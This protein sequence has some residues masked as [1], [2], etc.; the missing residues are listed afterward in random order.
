M[1]SYFFGHQDLPNHDYGLLG[2][3]MALVRA[4]DLNLVDSIW[5]AYENNATGDAVREDILLASRDPFAVDWYA[6]EYILRP[7]TTVQGSSAA[8]GG[9]FRKSTR[10]NQ[11]A[12]TLTWPGGSSNYPYIDFLDDY[13]GE[14]PSAAEHDQL[15][16]YV[17]TLGPGD[18]DGEEENSLTLTSPNGSEVWHIGSQ[19]DI[20]WTSTGVDIQSVRLSYSTDGFAN[21]N[22]S[23]TDNTPN[24]GKYP[25]WMPLLNSGT[26]SV[27]VSSASDPTIYDD[28]D[29]QF[30]IT[31]S[32]YREYIPFVFIFFFGK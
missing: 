21:S 32:F 3:Q 29:G 9:L 17:N 8:R 23:I 24:D 16:A 7:I 2:R 4:P 27:R 22:I 5:V 26:V 20:T 18:G 13:D 14:A 28:S 30:T 31:G 11:N 25:W 19:H 12:A 6:S 10:I 1:H 15:N